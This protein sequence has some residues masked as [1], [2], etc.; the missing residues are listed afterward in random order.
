[1]DRLIKLSEAAK[2]LGMSHW[3]LRRRVHLNKV[4]FIKRDTHYYFKESYIKQLIGDSSVKEN[5]E[6]IVWV[7][8]R[9]STHKQKEDLIRQKDRVCSYCQGRGYKINRIFKEIGSGINDSRCK[10]KFILQNKN[11]FD[12][13]VVE[14]KDRFSRVSFNALN[15]LLDNKIEVINTAEDVIT[16]LTNDLVSIMTSFCAK[17]YG[18][19]KGK[20][21]TTELKKI[22]IEDN[23]KS[24]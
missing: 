15:I 12:I 11:K 8:A 14:H 9:V 10:F 13:L 16:D 19:R 24:Y 20:R 17:L 6:K 18:Q 4:E 5:K 21:K 2:I 1:M 7:Y 22:L 23:A 3:S